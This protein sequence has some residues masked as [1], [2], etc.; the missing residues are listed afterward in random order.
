MTSPFDWRASGPSA[1]VKDPDF[2]SIKRSKLVDRPKAVNG[3]VDPK[4]ETPRGFSL[5]LNNRPKK[6]QKKI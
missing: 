3:L 1:F 2:T 6:G 4:L 5:T